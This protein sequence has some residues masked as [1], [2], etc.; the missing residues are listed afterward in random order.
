VEVEFWTTPL[1]VNEEHH[2]ID[3]QGLFDGFTLLHND[4]KHWCWIPDANEIFSVKSCHTS[5]LALRQIEFIKSI[6]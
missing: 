6:V 4:P 2:V 3:L 1:D 5:L